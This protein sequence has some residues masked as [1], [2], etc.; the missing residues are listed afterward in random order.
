M[1]QPHG[2]HGGE[3]HCEGMI[4]FSVNV[5]PHCATDILNDLMK[6]PHLW[7]NPYPD[8]QGKGLLN[9]IAEKEKCHIDEVLLGNGATQ[10]LY[11]LA[12][13]LKWKNVLIIEP[14]FTEY[15]RAFESVGTHC[16]SFMMNLDGPIESWLEKLKEKISTHQYDGLVVCRPNNPTGH[17]IKESHLEELLD[18]VQR[19]KLLI[20]ESFIDF[21]VQAQTAYHLNPDRIIILKSL[22]KYYGMAGLRLGYCIAQASL[23]KELYLEQHPWS[24]NGFALAY[25]ERILEDAS[26]K[27]QVDCWMQKEHKKMKT[28]LEQTKGLQVYPSHGNFFLLKLL[29]G[30]INLLLEK[31]LESKIIVRT[32]Q[33]FIGLGPDYIRIGLQS[34]IDNDLFI[35]RFDLCLKLVVS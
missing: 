10:C 21:V 22:T 20:D 13:T 28:F 12:T 18:G 24:L 35:H 25:G 33:D 31:L 6:T 2:H 16:D 17:Y 23:I 1:S 9:Q 11:L 8:S 30:D 27:N 7:L 3:A 15:R 5:Y 32:C 34:D 26:F 14:T 19:I 29:Q 4:D